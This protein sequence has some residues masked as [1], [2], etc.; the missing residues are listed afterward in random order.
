MH[1]NPQSKLD[2]APDRHQIF[3]LH[4]SRFFI[5]QPPASF[6]RRLRQLMFHPS[7]TSQLGV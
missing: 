2:A 5:S 1:R 3:D 6:S 4:H 7:G